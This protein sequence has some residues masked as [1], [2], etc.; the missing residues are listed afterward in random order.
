[1]LTDKHGGAG[2]LVVL[3]DDGGAGRGRQ[4]GFIPGI[5]LLHFAI[6]DI[7][8]NMNIKANII[9]LEEKFIFMLL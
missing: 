2:L 3:V 1:V 6:Y 5:G 7:D 8:K 4:V 9:L